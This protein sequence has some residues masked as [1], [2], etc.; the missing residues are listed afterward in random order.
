V[1][2]VVIRS[3]S[4]VMH[5]MSYK[6]K[7]GE[8]P[9]EELRFRNDVPLRNAFHHAGYRPRTDVK[10]TFGHG[11]KAIHVQWSRQVSANGR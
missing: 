3:E 1:K 4:D 10:K 5:C 2:I 9:F 6:K 7:S 11:V 8:M